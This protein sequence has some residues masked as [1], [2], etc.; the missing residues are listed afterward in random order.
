[1]L[2]RRCFLEESARCA[3]LVARPR[4]QSGA[5]AE[6]PRLGRRVRLGPG[7]AGGDGARRHIVTTSG[8][9]GAYPWGDEP[10]TS[11]LTIVGRERNTRV[12]IETTGEVDG[13]LVGSSADGVWQ[14]A[15]LYVVSG[16]RRTMTEI[17]RPKQSRGASGFCL[18]GRESV[19]TFMRQGW[20]S[21]GA[22]VRL[23]AEAF[24]KG[25]RILRS[26]SLAPMSC[27][28]PRP[29]GDHRVHPRRVRRWPNTMQRPA[30]KSAK[31]T[32]RT[33]TEE[34]T[35]TSRSCHARN[36]KLN[37][38]LPGTYAGDVVGADGNA[39]LRES[40]AFLPGVGSLKSI[41]SGELVEKVVGRTRLRN[42]GNN[43]RQKCDSARNT[44]RV[45]VRPTSLP[46]LF[47]DCCSNLL[48]LLIKNLGYR[49]LRRGR[50]FTVF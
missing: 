12:E 7:L 40:Q 4:G 31:R 29:R 41:S 9:E 22:C 10:H 34:L 21:P 13:R 15:D 14:F 49:R 43:R 8:L 25:G 39:A 18:V 3:G 19:F 37:M 16:S 35:P 30:P 24:T 32:H 44:R 33:P 23:T 45:F 2:L 47:A 27:F 6:G 48:H 38:G 36:G 26:T 1:V 17:D 42:S 50:C 5:T 20:T 11:Y 28:F 46:S